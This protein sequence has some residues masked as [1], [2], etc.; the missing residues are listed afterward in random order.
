V[1][2]DLD[3]KDGDTCSTEE[4]ATKMFQVPKFITSWQA[5]SAISAARQTLF[6]ALAHTPDMDLNAISS[7]VPEGADA[8]TIKAAVLGYDTRIANLVNHESWYRPHTL[9][10]DASSRSSSDNPGDDGSDAESSVSKA[11]D[12]DETSSPQ[13]KVD[14]DTSTAP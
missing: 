8:Q 7:G 2:E 4:L 6:M 13:A 3:L 12:D 11:E 10:E 1:A 5:S 14:D 9:A